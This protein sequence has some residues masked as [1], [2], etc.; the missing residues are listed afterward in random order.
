MLTVKR[1]QALRAIHIRIPGEP[2]NEAILILDHYTMNLIPDLRSGNE[3][4]QV[5]ILRIIHLS[6]VYFTR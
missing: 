5:H 2:G 6:A 1:Y 3:Y 4:S